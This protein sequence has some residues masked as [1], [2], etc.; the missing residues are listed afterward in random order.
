MSKINKGQGKNNSN[1]NRQN[2]KTVETSTEKMH[3]GLKIKDAIFAI[4]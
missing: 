2:V 3:V 4:K 1:N